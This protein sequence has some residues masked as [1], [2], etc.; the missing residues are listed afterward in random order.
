MLSYSRNNLK[1]IVASISKNKYRNEL[2]KLGYVVIEDV[3][4]R[5]R[6]EERY[7]EKLKEPLKLFDYSLLS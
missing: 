1:H 7:I 4:P 5:K 6:G 2:E 3:F